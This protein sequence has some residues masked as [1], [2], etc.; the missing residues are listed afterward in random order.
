MLTWKEDRFR[1]SPKLKLFYRACLPD[2]VRGHV[3]V[4]HGYAEHSGRYR[5]VMEYLAG[6]GYACYAPDCRGH[7]RTARCLGDLESFDGI[8]GDLEAF[9]DFI[10]GAFNARPIFL[11]GHSLGGTLALRLSGPPATGLSGAVVIAPTFVI[12][13]FASPL[14]IAVSGV[15]AALLPRLPA[16]AFPIEHLSRDPAVIEAIRRDPLYYRGKMR[17]R[18]GCQILHGIRRVRETAKRVSLPLLVLHG[19]EDRVMPTG[20]S[21]ELIETVASGDK[22]LVVYDGLYHEILNEPE[23]AQALGAVAS[24]LDDRNV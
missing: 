24:W 5:H 4:I 1:V 13:D 2:A 12:P 14:L 20:G 18:T 6:R 8:A 16:Q 22:S 21:R 7:G 3:I 17:A 10:T 19:S 23:R 15:L 11:L 9:K